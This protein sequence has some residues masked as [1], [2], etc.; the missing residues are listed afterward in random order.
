MLTNT[1]IAL[2]AAVVLSVSFGSFA[3]AQTAS[4]SCVPNNAEGGYRSA[5]PAWR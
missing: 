4:R 3:N 2:I 5:L 1:T